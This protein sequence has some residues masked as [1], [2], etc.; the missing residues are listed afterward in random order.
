MQWQDSHVPGTATDAEPQIKASD[1][2]YITCRTKPL[3]VFVNTKSGPMLGHTLRRKFLRLLNP[4]QV[5][6]ENMRL[7]KF[8]ELY[9]QVHLMIRQKSLSVLLVIDKM[10]HSINL[11]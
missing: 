2:C 5:M 8:L 7:L 6:A 9:K 11:L 4:L 1:P 10:S 3:L